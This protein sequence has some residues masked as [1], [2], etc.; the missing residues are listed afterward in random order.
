MRFVRVEWDTEYRGFFIDP[1]AYRQEL[2]GLL[3]SLPPGAANYAAEPG[4][5]DFGSR[6]CVKDLRLAEVSAP[7]DK[8]GVLS[9]RFTPS[10]WKHDEG[11]L[12][13]YAEVTRFTLDFER[14]ADW[15]AVEA[16]L[17]D[18]V[19]PREGGCSHEIQLTDSRI[20]V[21]CADLTS[22]WA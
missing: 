15:M 10:P 9:L 1:G 18:E 4:H 21:E 3:G 14:A 12:L 2:P 16:V 17:M 7:V 22:T 13:R 8:S 11:L 20:L 6:R 5:F 19:L